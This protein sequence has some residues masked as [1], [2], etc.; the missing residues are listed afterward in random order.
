MQ[1]RTIMIVEDDADIR[2]ALAQAMRDAGAEVVVARDGV[3]ALERLRSGP[4]PA[5]ILLDLRLPRLGGQDFLE[6]LRSDVRFEHLPVITMTAGASRVEGDDL[7][8][9]LYKPVDVEDLRRIVESLF[10]LVPHSPLPA[11]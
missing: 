5:V 11:T 4:C 6:R 9:R 2:S 3:D 8:A 10:E 1:Q 7:L